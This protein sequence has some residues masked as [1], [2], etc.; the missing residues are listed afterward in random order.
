MMGVPIWKYLL[1][2][3]AIALLGAAAVFLYA[4]LSGAPLGWILRRWPGPTPPLWVQ[5][6]LYFVL[7]AL[8][9]GLCFCAGWL[10]TVVLEWL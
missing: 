6:L 5:I 9:L 1:V 2:V 3:V 10:I 8:A 4:P 7:S